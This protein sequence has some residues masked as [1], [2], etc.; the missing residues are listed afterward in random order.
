MNDENDRAIASDGLVV[1]QTVSNRIAGYDAWR[2]HKA[3]CRKMFEE[4][5]RSLKVSRVEYLVQLDVVVATHKALI[6]DQKI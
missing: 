6:N 2:A 3:V 4:A 1:N 5:E